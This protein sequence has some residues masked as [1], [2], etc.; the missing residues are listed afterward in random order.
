MK[1]LT[2]GLMLMSSVALA[3][4]KIEVAEKTLP[5]DGKER[6]CLTVSVKGANVEEVSKA[7]K[8]Q[9][10]DLKG[11]VDDKTVI[12]C[13]D[14]KD[15]SMGDNTFDVYSIVELTRDTSARLAA[16]FDLGGADLSSAEHPEKYA[17]AAKIVRA[18]GVE[19]A[20]AVVQGQ[21]DASEKTLKSLEKDL[22]K[23]QK[24]KEKSEKTITDSKGEI[25][26]NNESIAGNVAAQKAKQGEKSRL[27]A[28]QIEKPSDE[29]AKVIK[30]YEK[31]L[32]GMVKDKKKLEKDIEKLEEKIKEEQAAIKQ[33]EQDQKAKQ[34]EI[35]DM[36]KVIHNLEFKL[37]EIR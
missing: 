12:F 4:E 35:D 15:K 24:D 16:A 20:K 9:L 2:V 10:K 8:K 27:E 29:V 11:K 5:I 3:Q 32:D 33:N 28:G 13:D 1:R 21:I 26:A 14:C 23:L 37:K 34:K 19:Q 30:G 7:W 17:A 6:N 31:D 36:K 22:D 25:A 18:F